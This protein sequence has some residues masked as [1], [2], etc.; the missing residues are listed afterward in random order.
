LLPGSWGG[1]CYSALSIGATCALPLILAHF[2]FRKAWLTPWFALLLFFASPRFTG[3][4][5]FCEMNIATI[6]YCAGFA[7][8]VPGIQRNR[9]RWFYIVVFLAAMVKFTFLAMLLLPL[10]A[11]RRQ[12]IQSLLCGLAVGA[13]NMG[14]GM[15]WPAEYQQYQWAMTKGILDQQAFGFGILGIMASYNSKHSGGV[16]TAPFIISGL[17]AFTPLLLMFLLWRKLSR[18]GAS[19]AA[20]TDPASSDPAASNPAT[21]ALASNGN[22]L[23]LVVSTIILVNPRLMQY[24][25]DIALLAA[26]V[27]WVYGLRAKRLILLMLL[28]FLPSMVV[29]LMVLNPHLHGIYTAAVAYAGFALGYWRLWQEAAI[30]RTSPEPPGQIAQDPRNLKALDAQKAQLR[31]IG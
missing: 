27:L 19:E 7:A 8:A 29:P 28:L 11:A 18:P 5:V 4:L 10:L 3:L 2:Y 14:Q 6:L 24:D 9:W 13:A 30:S 1:L 16:G 26:F 15:L 21:T 12:W 20:T 17:V 22:W 23:A 31:Q 25:V